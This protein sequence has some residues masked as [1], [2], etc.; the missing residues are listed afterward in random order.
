[1]ITIDDLTNLSF[2]HITEYFD[3]IIELQQNKDAKLMYNLLDDN[4]KQNFAE[5]LSV[6]CFYDA[7]DND[8]IPEIEIIVYLND[9][10]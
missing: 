5:Y 2:N 3:W 6:N 7:L 1:M 10:K 8:V 9:L 4:Q